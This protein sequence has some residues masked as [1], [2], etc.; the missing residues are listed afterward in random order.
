MVEEARRER[1]AAKYEGLTPSDALQAVVDLAAQ[2]M[3]VPLAMVNVV[4]ASAQQTIVAHGMELAGTSVPVP[5]SIC[6]TV[7]DDAAPVV[8][9]DVLADTARRDIAKL[10]EHAGFRSYIGVPIIGR[11]GLPIGTLCVM[12]LI[13][14]GADV[15]LAALRQYAML[16]E[17]A[18]EVGRSAREILAARDIRDSSLTVTDITDAVDSGDIAPWYMPIVD[19]DTNRLYAAEALARWSRPDGVTTLPDAFLPRIENTELIID[20]DLVMLRRSLIDLLRWIE[21]GAAADDLMVTVNFSAHH[22]YRRGCVDRIDAVVQEVGAE[23]SSV[24]LEVTETTTVPTRALIDAHV[25]DALR[26]RGYTVILDDIGG[27][28]LPA[29]HLLSLAFDGLKADRSIGAALQTSVGHALGSALATLAERLGIY[30][31]IEGIETAEQAR[32]AHEIGVRRGQ[33]FYWSEAVPATGMPELLARESL[34][35]TLG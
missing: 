27:D 11:E 9:G 1:S 32:L 23:P 18:L 12:G 3:R 20:F 8:I 22:F 14:L 10:V 24:I 31:I 29:K 34:L 2:A 33:G 17:Q 13:P 7:V 25:V 6:A 15:D 5:E 35:P 19:L 30:L 28:W 4:G 21:T 26:E 16:A